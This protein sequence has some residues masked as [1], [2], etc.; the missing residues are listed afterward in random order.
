M[1][2]L[3]FNPSKESNLATFMYSEP[4]ENPIILKELKTELSKNF[5]DIENYFFHNKDKWK[6]LHYNKPVIDLN[7]IYKIER[8][9]ATVLLYT[10]MKFDKDYS[11]LL[12]H[13][14]GANTKIWINN[15]LIAKFDKNNSPERL[16][17]NKFKDYLIPVE[18]KQGL[19]HVVIEVRQNNV[20]WDFEIKFFNYSYQPLKEYT[21]FIP[22]QT[23]D[24]EFAHHSL[25]DSL[26]VDLQKSNIEHKDDLNLIMHSELNT[27]NFPENMT[28]SIQITTIDNKIS[29]ERKLKHLPQNIFRFNFNRVDLD[30]PDGFYNLNMVF[31]SV[32][33]QKTR[34]ISSFILISNFSGK[35]QKYFE[36]IN[37][38]KQTLS[39]SKKY[40]KL[41][42]Y[43]LPRVEY[44]TLLLDEVWNSATKGIEDFNLINTLIKEIEEELDL[45]EEKKDPLLKKTGY[46]KCAYYNEHS[47]DPVPYSIYLPK[48]YNK[49]KKYPVI[50]GL[51]GYK[52]NHY[53][54]IKRFFNLGI[55]KNQNDYIDPHDLENIPNIDC[56]VVAINGYGSIGYDS[57]AETDFFNTY[58]HIK[59]YYS[60][61]ENKIYIVGIS[62][63]GAGA[64][65]LL[66]HYPDYFA[67]GALLC[68][69]YDFY[70]FYTP[71]L[72]SSLIHG[73]KQLIDNYAYSNY[74]HNLEHIPLYIFHGTNDTVVPVEH[75]RKLIDELNE[76]GFK[77]IYIEFSGFNHNIWDVVFQNFPLTE[78]LTKHTKENIYNFT[79][80]SNDT[81]YNKYNFIEILEPSY[82]RFTM[83]IKTYKLEDKLFIEP[84]NIKYFK[85]LKDKLDYKT[86]KHIFVNGVELALPKIKKSDLIITLEEEQNPK[87][88]KKYSSPEA[89]KPKQGIFQAFKEWHTFVVSNNIDKR[90]KNLLERLTYYPY[91]EHITFPILNAEK[92]DLSKD[93][94]GN[95]ILIGTPDTNIHI[96]KLFEKLHFTYEN[97]KIILFGKEY[98]GSPV[99]A[100]F[101][102]KNIFNPKH[103][104]VCYLLSH[105]DVIADE[106]IK[107]NIWFSPFHYTDVFIF[108]KNELIHQEV[109]TNDWPSIE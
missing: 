44:K 1:S 25:F 28:A 24:I 65:Y 22:Y 67:A 109:F 27:C 12:Q 61:D 51:H 108:N 91:M 56:I 89:C 41:F 99:Q 45:L 31:E 80:V 54:F 34:H 92:A 60:I 20:D 55:N 106:F 59:N 90:T 19:N 57:Y 2:F 103:E 101:H 66:S 33:F 53:I 7:E 64:L 11:A 95:I 87:I 77:K 48:N 43:S 97:N 9:N 23:D 86:I 4:I 35:L 47:D 37:N 21:I 18:F 79:F 39:K 63:G 69:V 32:L 85:I 3:S 62:M 30:I 38:L 15:V 6:F 49:N 13:S 58:N 68:P 94:L 76:L 36:R 74:L 16:N 73:Q 46:I 83:K 52:A 100:I 81:N 14:G 71:E 96:K 98:H 42:D 102:Y 40:K 82:N 72:K 10:I 75:S 50:F 105:P 5:N 84:N 29:F 107:P 104:I 26:Q 70:K 93:E 88:I 17:L 8:K 78:I